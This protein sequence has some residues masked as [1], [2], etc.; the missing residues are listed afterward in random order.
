MKINWK[1]RLKNKTFWLAI[2]PAVLLVAQIVGSWFGV[3][4]PAEFITAEAE[5]FI[6]AVFIVLMILGI[7]SDPTT[8]GVNDSK[9]AQGYEK[10]KGD[11]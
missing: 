7:V 9:Q 8:K 3:E 2:I 1:V 5:R 6:N 11:A 10:P 4:V